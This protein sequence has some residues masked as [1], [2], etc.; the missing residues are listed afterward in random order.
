MGAAATGSTC[1]ESAAWRWSSRSRDARLGSRDSRRRSDRHR[2]LERRA[3]A[4]LAF[5]PDAAAMQL[6]DLLRDREAEARADHR[7]RLG[8]L[9]P[10]VACEHLA[11]VLGRN[12]DAVIAHR[13][14]HVS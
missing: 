3:F 7:V 4:Q 10:F 2:E 14:I 5:H 11:D 6:D 9:E 8:A 1:R 12:A 13:N